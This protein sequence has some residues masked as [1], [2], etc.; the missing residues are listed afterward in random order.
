M[1]R[2]A[3]AQRGFTLTE[4]M[5][6]IAIVGVLAMLASNV[7]DENGE[8]VDG[9]AGQITSELVNARL[10][11]MADQKWQRM[12]V[13]GGSLSL[14]EGNTTGMAPPTSWAV[15]YTIAVPSVAKIV[16]IGQTA[17]INATGAAAPAGT[18]LAAGVTFAPD[19]SSVARTIYLQDDQGHNPERLIVFAT[20]G[21][22]LRRQGW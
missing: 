8:T 16:S 12:V 10:R 4:L 19:G 11:A 2:S 14:Q 17:S 5:I 6:T 22:V 20:T 1:P 9:A 15:T 7:T 13:T 18:G 21:T 3:P